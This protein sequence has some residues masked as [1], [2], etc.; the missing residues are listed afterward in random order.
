MDQNASNEDAEQQT[1]SITHGKHAEQP[2]A[3][4]ASM[5]VVT[6]PEV[7]MDIDLPRLLRPGGDG[8]A[9][10]KMVRMEIPDSEDASEIS[11]PIKIAREE[12][13]DEAAELQDG[14][15]E[16]R[17]APKQYLEQ[18]DT[19]KAQDATIIMEVSDSEEVSEFSSP[20]KVGAGAAT[21]HDGPLQ[22]ASGLESIGESPKEDFEEGDTTM[23]DVSVSMRGDGL[24][25]GEASRAV[26]E[27]GETKMSVTR[28]VADDTKEMEHT[29]QTDKVLLS[30]GDRDGEL[31]QRTLAAETQDAPTADTS[32]ILDETKI[33]EQEALSIGTNVGAA[34]HLV[35]P[36]KGDSGALKS[37]AT[38][39]GQVPLSSPAL[40]PQAIAIAARKLLADEVSPTISDVSETTEKPKLLKSIIAIPDSDE[41]EDNE[42]PD[43]PGIQQRD[44][45]EPASNLS[46]TEDALLFSTTKPA[47]TKRTSATSAEVQEVAIAVK[48][49]QKELTASSIPIGD[50]NPEKDDSSSLEPSSSPVK[51]DMAPPAKKNAG[52]KHSPAKNQSPQSTKPQLAAELTSSPLES[53]AT[54]KPHKNSFEQPVASTTEASSQA[55]DIPSSPLRMIKGRSFKNKR[56][57]SPTAS[58][59]APEASQPKDLVMAELKAMKIASIQ[60]RISALEIEIASKRTK[61]E[62]VTKDLKQPAAETVK[63]HIRLL[64]EYNDIRDVGQGLVGMIA[65]NR[66]VRIGELYEEFGVG[67]KD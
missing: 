55:T 32:P 59:T 54:D 36:V 5:D 15:Q 1:R 41:D 14:L 21:S 48:G 40:D 47:A 4:G 25:K 37:P 50:G 61:L 65:D 28:T 42:L 6:T 29:I 12:K 16:H 43:A 56:K 63:R 39:G 62:E 44:F 53:Q 17:Q 26:D 30:N 58:S 46:S 49:H 27:A 38:I 24:A 64:H 33:L 22:A 18:R 66:G 13:C 2:E 57:E 9:T 10:K 7:E 23:M 8:N 52:A 19:P 51:A 45:R 60:N 31:V 11:S 20:F 67:L 34:S 35:T 3:A